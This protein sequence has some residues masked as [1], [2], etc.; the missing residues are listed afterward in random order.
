MTT[1]SA[2]ARKRRRELYEKEIGDWTDDEVIEV[3]TERYA[4]T[5]V[6][7]CR[8]CGGELSIQAVG[9]GQPTQ[10]AHQVMKPEGGVDWDHYKESAWEDR[11]QGGDEAVIDLIRRFKGR[12]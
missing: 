9:G 1:T 7:P 2:E 4:P 5:D 11:R 6:P 8:V 12:E 3:L 10:Y